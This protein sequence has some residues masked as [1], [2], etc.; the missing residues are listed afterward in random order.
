MRPLICLLLLLASPAAA[1]D[2]LSF[3]SPT[4][5]IGC[6]IFTGGDWAGA[7]C[8]LRDLTP[9]YRNRPADCDLDWGSAFFVGSRGPGE[10]ACVGDT[11]F[12][13]GAFTLD[14]GKSVSLGAFVCTSERSGMTCTNGQGHGFSVARARQRVF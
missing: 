11:V 7:R 4:G 6:A 12:D 10:V 3:R 13:P 14:Y 2:Y 5:N 9:S 1:Q 8:D